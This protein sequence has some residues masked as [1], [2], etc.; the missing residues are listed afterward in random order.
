[1]F[2][3]KWYVITVASVIGLLFSLVGVGDIPAAKAETDGVA[4]GRDGV[5][6]GKGNAPAGQDTSGKTSQEADSIE[7][8]RGQS[9][10]SSPDGKVLYGIPRVML[11][12]RVISPSKKSITEFVNVG[13][14]TFRRVLSQVD[15]T[16]VFKIK[17]VP[18]THQ[19]TITFT[20]PSWRW[21]QWAYTV[22]LLRE[23]SMIGTATEKGK[24]LKIQLH[25]SGP[26]GKATGL[27]RQNLKRVKSNEYLAALRNWEKK[28]GPPNIPFR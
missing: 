4:A 14:K 6:A 8:Y 17:S 25:I 24:I 22:D 15:D 1:M 10:D 20:G 7:Y 18:F 9:Q 28:R 23:G 21:K 16:K 27:V 13:L 2:V 11:L 26:K 3:S 5:E 19:G 12:K